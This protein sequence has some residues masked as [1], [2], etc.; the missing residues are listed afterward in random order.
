MCAMIQKFLIFFIGIKCQK[1]VCVFGYFHPDQ[2][3]IIHWLSFFCF[4]KLLSANIVY[5]FRDFFD[6]I[7]KKCIFESKVI[8]T[9]FDKSKGLRKF[10]LRNIK[11]QP[12]VPSTEQRYDRIRNSSLFTSDKKRI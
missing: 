10:V 2:P 7:L 9:F 12:S 3:L 1:N 11:P 5:F 4:P 6:L 8:L